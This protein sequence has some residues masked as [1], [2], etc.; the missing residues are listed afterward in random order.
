MAEN[1]TAYDLHMSI[2]NVDYN[3]RSM[4]TE[5]S[6][7]N[8]PLDTTIH[9][10]TASHSNLTG[11]E[12]KKLKYMQKGKMPT[13]AGGAA[14]G[15]LIGNRLTNDGTG[16]V[17]GAGIGGVAGAALHSSLNSKYNLEIAQSVLKKA[18]KAL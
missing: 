6:Y 7:K 16:T 18:V 11:A 4:L 5:L 13:V 14:L 8:A 2:K 10:I 12:I 9:K 1:K 3:A 17:V 15:A